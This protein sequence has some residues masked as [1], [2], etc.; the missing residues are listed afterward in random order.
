MAVRRKLSPSLAALMSAAAALAPDAYGQSTDSEESDSRVGYRFNEYSE[1]AVDG[2]YLGDPDR[3]RVYSQQFQLDTRVGNSSALDVTATHEVMSGSSP[4][5][6]LP[7]PGNRPIQVLSG[8]TI[9]DHRSALSAAYT[10]DA[11]TSSSTTYS[12][13]YSQERDYRATSLGMERSF[14]LNAAL[15]LGAGGSF[16]HDIIQ[17]TD[18]E[19]FDRIRYA[20]KNTGSLFGSL[21]WVIDKSTVVQTGIQLNVEDGYLS[22]PYKLVSVGDDTLPDT[23]PGTRTEVAWLLRYRRAFDHPDGALHLDYR[24]A[25]DSWGVASSTVDASWYQTLGDGWQLVPEARYYSQQQARFYAP[26][27]LDPGAHQFFSS[28]YRLGTFGA[29]S[30]SLNVRKRVAHWQLSA[31]LERYHAS[32]SYAIGG[33]DLADPGV[34]SYTRA[35]IGADYLFE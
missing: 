29:L 16:S 24:Y 17:P 10:A 11:G 34:I 6:V 35:F 28:D 31:G 4:W 12:A 21:A 19:L 26:F 15:T 30:A 27:F 2:P 23:R 9:H 33:A 5:F 32:T 20:D 22:D 25:Q 3:Y 8:A 13:S 7:G 1:D 18:Y 14:P